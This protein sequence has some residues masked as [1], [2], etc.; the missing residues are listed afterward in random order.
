[1]PA[2]VPSSD[3]GTAT[4]GITVA[5]GLR[6]KTNTTKTTR[7]MESSSVIWTSWKEA[8]IVVVRSSSTSRSIAGEIEARSSGSSARTRSTVS[9]MLLPG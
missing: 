6:R 7:P 3:S 2:K 4:L 8:R 1:M 9:M 5:A